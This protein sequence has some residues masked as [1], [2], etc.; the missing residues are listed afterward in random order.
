[1]ADKDPVGVPGDDS[2]QL[3]DESVQLQAAVSEL[4][5]VDIPFDEEGMF[6]RYAEQGKSFGHKGEALEKFV[7]KKLAE[8]RDRHERCVQREKDRQAQLLMEEKRVRLEGQ[9]IQL[10][11][12]K[13]QKQEEIEEKKNAETRIV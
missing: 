7:E 11:R 12:E 3:Q 13:I 6:A 4:V 2:D 9:K 1:M 10:E 5:H 8:A